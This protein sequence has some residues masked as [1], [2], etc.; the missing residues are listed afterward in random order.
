MT[1]SSLR[2]GVGYRERRHRARLIR[3]AIVAGI[4]VVCLLA[5]G[6]WRLTLGPVAVPFLSAYL[7]SQLEHADL[8][9]EA[10]WDAA[11]IHWPFMAPWLYVRFSEF[12]AS[13]VLTAEGIGI[14][15]PLRDLVRGQ[16]S[17]AGVVLYAPTVLLKQGEGGGFGLGAGAAQSGSE[18]PLAAIA[19]GT[20]I[21]VLDGTIT[22]E[23]RRSPAAIQVVGIQ[24]S[25]ME[26]DG[27]VMFDGTGTA[28]LPAHPAV[29]LELAAQLLPDQGEI[30][31]ELAFRGVEPKAVAEFVGLSAPQAMLQVPL[32]GSVAVT[33]PLEATVLRLTATGAGGQLQVPDTR[34]D[35]G[36]AAVP[37]SSMEVSL[38]YGMESG[39][40]DLS[41]L[42]LTG[43]V[44]DLRIKG[45]LQNAPA[46]PSE[47]HAKFAGSLSIDDLAAWL[48]PALDPSTESW[49]RKRIDGG[50]LTNLT[51]TAD[52]PDGFAAGSRLGISGVVRETA[53][54]WEEG[55][56]TLDLAVVELDLAGPELTVVAPTATI[57]AATLDDLRLH[58]ADLFAESGAAELTARL[59]G[60]SGSLL[61]QIGLDRGP[62]A[63]PM[64]RGPL[65][66]AELR[67]RIPFA[68]DREAEVTLRG[69]FQD[70]RV[71][72]TSFPVGYSEFDLHEL[73]GTWT[74]G[75]GGIDVQF[76]GKLG[77]SILIDDAVLTAS[78]PEAS[79][80]RIAA[81]LHGSLA[82]L[83]GLGVTAQGAGRLPSGVDGLAGTARIRVVMDVPRQEG[84]GPGIRLLEGVFAVPSFTAG[85]F[86]SGPWEGREFRDV[87]GAV[88]LQGETLTVSGAAALA[89]SE[90]SFA[91][92][93]PLPDVPGDQEL[94]VRGLLWPEARN[95]LGIEFAD[96][97]GPLDLAGSAL[98][99][100]E[101]GRWEVDIE[102]GLS[103]AEV[104]IPA[105]DWT[106][107]A[108]APLHAKVRGPLARGEPLWLQLVGG[109]TDVAG[110]IWLVDGALDRLVFARLQ[111]GGH[112]LTG[113]VAQGTDG[114]L[115]AVLQ[116]DQADLRPFLSADSET[117]AKPEPLRL[118]VDSRSAR[119]MA[120]ALAG[121]LVFT[122]EADE[123][124]VQELHLALGLPDEER[125]ELRGVGTEGGLEL[126][127]TGTNARSMADAFGLGVAANDGAV[128]IEAIR[129]DGRI[130]G[131]VQVGE[132][133]M[134]DAPVFLQLLQTVT[135]LGLLE[136]IAGGGGVA[137]SSFD[138][139]FTFSD[140][141]ID[142]RN[143]I[144]QGLTLGVT[145]EGAIDTQ[146]RLLDLRGALIPAYAVNLLLT[147]VPVIDQ[148]I[149][150]TDSMGVLA[151]DYAVTGL[152]AEPEIAVSPLQFLM[153]GV[154]R[155]LLQGFGNAPGSPP[156]PDE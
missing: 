152:A 31:A 21:E 70:I 67:V 12:R 95:A 124:G 50:T 91:W 103:A 1:A 116:G 129:K 119:T 78:G 22:L 115:G 16:P 155:N 9:V 134:V 93:S 46:G 30:S 76:A 44:G 84:V 71:D 51:L 110:R 5:A 20:T 17:V 36:R 2:P 143:G 64:L 37:I 151:A 43:P 92:R 105:L 62:A 15:V 131:T 13:D 126:E 60:D 59:S 102:A 65:R 120:P 47:I 81:T 90:L 80:F 130:T 113:T 11:A 40:L 42:A 49:V 18:S 38:E 75:S 136:Q 41:E 85:G 57:G 33:G 69:E 123:H 87:T 82:D 74:Y 127:L 26:V 122:M 107:P 83:I 106:K 72:P 137:F 32:S 108:H 128:R 121:P 145:V 99:R 140:G 147:R 135:V 55:E 146:S 58:S 66:D 94:I 118:R 133:T 98:S 97:D 6:I 48:G 10:R 45:S 100:A 8:P 156:S 54:N 142:I 101:S 35:A 154:L 86:G 7:A 39:A 111:I 56:P 89:D 53:I 24:A 29:P 34:T 109:G 68:S 141:V 139:D 149:T 3:S 77:E 19:S 117:L 63:E 79:S 125:M 148:L 96:V 14:R 138:A 104:T 114:Y 23:P 112:R 73:A 27:Q 4:I 61:Q 132:F 153:P 52:F 88:A 150:G 144:A 25:V 28:S